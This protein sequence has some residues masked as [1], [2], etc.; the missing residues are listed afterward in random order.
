MYI[1]IYI[2]VHIHINNIGD[3]TNDTNKHNIN[4]ISHNDIANTT[5]NTNRKLTTTNIII[6]IVFIVAV[7]KGFLYDMLLLSSM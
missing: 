2:H 4:M 1:Y 3:S 5:A 6:V 7:A